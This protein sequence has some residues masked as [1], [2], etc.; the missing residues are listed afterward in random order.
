MFARRSVLVL[1]CTALLLVSS[2]RLQAGERP[3]RSD[4]GITLAGVSDGA[5][6]MALTV[7]AHG[8]VRRLEGGACQRLFDAF[9]DRNG[10]PLR[11]TLEAHAWS[12]TDVAS[13]VVFRDGRETTTCRAG[14]IA[15][16][17][18]PGSRVVFVC[19]QRF[20]AMDRTRAELVL[21]HEFLHTLGLEE[22]PPLPSEIDAAVAGAC[23][24]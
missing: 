6:A 23:V 11:A 18:G 13:R 16:F 4:G 9:A 12:V 8:A 21:V 24:D 20:A 10:L 2:A 5:L 19:G 3:G 1:V 22:R 7:A 17:T 14:N 15:A